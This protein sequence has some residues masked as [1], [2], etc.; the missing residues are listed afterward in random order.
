MLC[1]SNG[2]DNKIDSWVTTFCKSFLV[3]YFDDVVLFLGAICQSSCFRHDKFCGYATYCLAKMVKMVQ[4]VGSF[5]TVCDIIKHIPWDSYSIFMW[6]QSPSKKFIGTMLVS[7]AGHDWVRHLSHWKGLSLIR[8][9]A[10]TGFIKFI[11]HSISMDCKST[12]AN[13]RSR[14]ER[15]HCLSQ[16]LKYLLLATAVKNTLCAVLL[17]WCQC[18]KYFATLHLILRL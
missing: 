12:A 9:V 13:K 7:V 2:T 17:Y 4:K 8:E 14:Q 1:Y 16:M 15:L 10:S 6:I 5:I 3:L 18:Q 11:W